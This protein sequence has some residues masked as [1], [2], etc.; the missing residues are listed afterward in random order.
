[1][2]KKQHISGRCHWSQV[3]AFTPGCPV[4]QATSNIPTHITGSRHP[5][6]HT[7]SVILSGSKADKNTHT[8]I[9]ADGPHWN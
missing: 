8:F 3:Q 9:T 7:R 1:M 6:W 5:H 2:F 4:S